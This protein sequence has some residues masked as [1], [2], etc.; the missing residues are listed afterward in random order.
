MRQIKP[1]VPNRDDY[2]TPL[3]IIGDSELRYLEEVTFINI[4]RRDCLSIMMFINN[5]NNKIIFSGSLRI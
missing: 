3:Y 2:E 4:L 1:K 5:D